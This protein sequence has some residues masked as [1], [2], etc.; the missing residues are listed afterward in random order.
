VG[1][2][3]GIDGAEPLRPEPV[4]RISGP[5]E[6]RRVGRSGLLAVGTL[7]CPACDAPVAPSE[8]SMAPAAPLHCPFCAHAGAVRDFLSLALPSRPARV[9]VRV[10]ER[11][12]AAAKL[13]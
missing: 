9:E 4:G 3:R 11:P 2:E 6:E 7:A 5:R 12:R 1:F 10:V 8:A 13:G